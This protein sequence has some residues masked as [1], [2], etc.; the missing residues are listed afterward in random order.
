M[1][2][3][4]I[5]WNRLL[6]W[7][8]IIIS[9]FAA[10][11]MGCLI[12]MVE[13]NDQN[14]ANQDNEK[15]VKLINARTKIQTLAEGKVSHS[16]ELLLIKELEKLID[17]GEVDAELLGIPYQYANNDDVYDNWIER[18]KTLSEARY[19]AFLSDSI[20][21]L[22]KQLD[23]EHRRAT[24]QEIELAKS[25]FKAFKKSYEDFFDRKA[26]TEFHVYSMPYDKRS[27]YVTL[28]IGPGSYQYTEEHYRSII[29]GLVPYHDWSTGP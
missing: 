23:K 22:Q 15:Y 14:Q 8:F 24:P 28:D 11:F 2:Y 4:E 29:T 12:K 5:E 10:I 7:L 26:A 3:T 21:S 17:S 1:K 20:V 27:I 25:H 9:S 18:L 13:D 19:S 6:T 16:D